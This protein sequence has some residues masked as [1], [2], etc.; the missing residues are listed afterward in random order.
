MYLVPLG[1][2]LLFAGILLFV[3]ILIIYGMIFKKDWFY[4]AHFFSFFQ[5]NYFL[6]SEFGEK[7]VTIGNIILLFIIWLAWGCVFLHFK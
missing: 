6:K 3:T 4:D 5:N 1:F 2:S 7:G